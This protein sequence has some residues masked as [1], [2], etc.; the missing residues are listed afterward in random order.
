M[1]HTATQHIGK[2]YILSIGCFARKS[3]TYIITNRQ[4]AICA[5]SDCR[6]EMHVCRVNIV[7][8]NQI[9]ILLSPSW[10]ILY[11][12]GCVCVCVL[13]PRPNR[14][15]TSEK[16]LSFTCF[17]TLPFSFS[18]FLTFFLPF[19]LPLSLAPSFVTPISP[20]FSHPFSA[21]FYWKPAYLFP[22]PLPLLYL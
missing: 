22:S 12:W 9:N 3:F 14:F 21:W 2:K 6:W 20:F 7:Y 15:L 1:P 8:L 4:K 13:T 16:Q 19:L 18:S 11:S 5:V 17:H 10:W